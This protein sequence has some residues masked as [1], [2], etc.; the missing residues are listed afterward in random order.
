VPSSQLDASDVAA[1]ELAAAVGVH[2]I[3]VPTPFAIG[4][5][6]LYL[7]EGDT[8]GLVDAGPNAATALGA[9]EQGLG[10]LGHGIGDLDVVFVTHQHID[11]TGLAGEIARR[12]DAEVVCLDLLAPVLEDWAAFSQQDDDDAF[13][14]MSRHGV[15]PHVAEALHAVASVVR[16]WGAPAQV[17][18]VLSD[19]SPLTLG[20]GTFDALWRP[21]HSPTD[22][23]LHDSARGV[24][25]AGDHLLK[26]ISSNAVIARPVG[27]PPGPYEGPRPRPLVQYRESLRATREL[28][29][30]VAPGGHGGP[31]TDHRTLIDARLLDHERR[32]AQFLELLSGGPMTAHEMATARWG[33]VAITQAF[34][35]LSEILGHVDLLIA[36][37]AVVEDRSEHVIRFERA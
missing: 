37:G 24:L 5:V 32:A 18:R 21:G 10:A 16:G 20:D 33:E 30:D 22:T 35:T 3:P 12:A 9:L 13:L 14:L 25:L 6:N 29:F 34:L 23:V 11:H 28:D 36:D 15:E 26:D 19:G 17:D 1:L 27:H 7:V 31:V 2:R 8:L 4:D